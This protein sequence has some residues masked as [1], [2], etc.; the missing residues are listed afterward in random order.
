MA[1]SFVFPSN[2]VGMLLKI[3]LGYAVKHQEVTKIT[4]IQRFWLFLTFK[5]PLINRETWRNLVLTS[6][7]LQL[8]GILIR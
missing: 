1:A 5:F 2:L 7:I 6:P 3:A 4:Q 8:L